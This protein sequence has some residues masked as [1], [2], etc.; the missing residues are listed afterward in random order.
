MQKS[1][2][3]PHC[4]IHDIATHERLWLGSTRLR[5]L[6][7]SELLLGRADINVV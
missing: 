1:M 3:L 7:V 5:V 6:S 4:L 2:L